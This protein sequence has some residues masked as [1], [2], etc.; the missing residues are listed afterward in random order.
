MARRDVVR[1]EP[2][3]V[4]LAS[5]NADGTLRREG[6]FK[7]AAGRGVQE[8]LTGLFPP[9]IAINEDGRDT[10]PFA[11]TS[12]ISDVTG[13]LGIKY[14]DPGGSLGRFAFAT[15]NTR[16]RRQVTLNKKKT[17]RPNATA[18]AR[19]PRV[20]AGFN[21]ATWVAFDDQVY[22]FESEAWSGLLHTFA[23]N[24]IPQSAPVE[25]GGLLLFFLGASGI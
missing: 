9:V 3:E 5:R 16:H 18:G 15:V 23:G 1:V 14:M 10:Q 13:G 7:L 12:T 2:G 22:T 20:G 8:M 4:Y 21:D 6:R 19:L 11:S 17:A 25:W 24:A